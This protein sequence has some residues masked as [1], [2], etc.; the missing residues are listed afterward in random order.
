MLKRIG[1]I[2]G[3][4]W[5]FFWGVIAWIPLIAFCLLAAI[6]ALDYREFKNTWEEFI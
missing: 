5:G 1:F 3:L 4:I 2:L 6:A